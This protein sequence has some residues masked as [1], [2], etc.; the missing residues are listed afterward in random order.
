MIGFIQ[1]SFDNHHQLRNLEVKSGHFDDVSVS[2]EWKSNTIR[3]K[4]TFRIALLRSQYAWRVQ[5]SS[6]SNS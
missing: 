6:L 5:Y 2:Q 4:I 3:F 1:A